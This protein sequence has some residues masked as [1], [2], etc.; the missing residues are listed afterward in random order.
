MTDDENLTNKARER[1]VIHQVWSVQGYLVRPSRRFTPPTDIIEHD[2]RVVVFVEI[3]GMNRENF[4]IALSNQTLTVSGVRERPT[5]GS[6]AY[7][8]AEIGFGE[9]QVTVPLPWAIEAE[10]V[11][12]NYSNGFLR[13]DLPYQQGQQHAH[14]VNVN[15][16]EGEDSQH[17]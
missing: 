4:K 10:Q 5:V 12:A 11:T 8:Q 6:A 1:A 3:A 15:T 2:D 17:E 14:I 7:H 16:D 9:F 13:V